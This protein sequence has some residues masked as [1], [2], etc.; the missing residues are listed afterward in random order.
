MLMTIG[1]LVT[2]LILLAA[3]IYTDR[4]WLR[5]FVLGGTAVW[6]VFYSAM[7]L[8]F[9]L[10]S[11]EKNLTLNQPKAFCGFYLDCHM[12]TAVTDVKRTKTIGN[13]S[14]D[15][16]FYIVRVRVFSNAKQATLG[17]KGVAAHVVDVDGRTYSRNI[18]AE[19][20][21]PPQP[22][23]DER[24]SPV[25]SFEKEV[26]FDLPAD[27]TNP[28][29]DIREDSWIENVLEAVIINDE[30]SLLHKRVYFSLDSPAAQTAVMR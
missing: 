6:L 29:L 2:A 11:E 23:F 7:L 27:V 30:D 8:A 24:I 19:A 22:E 12:H 13:K 17:L 14:A 5:T 10:R 9:S 26:V 3:S 20:L 16:E 4:A 21:L 25:G 18:D 15:G 1:G 28:R